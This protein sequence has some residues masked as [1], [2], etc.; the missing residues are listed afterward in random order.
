VTGIL[1]TAEKPVGAGLAREG[2]SKVKTFIA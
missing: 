1:F 2:V